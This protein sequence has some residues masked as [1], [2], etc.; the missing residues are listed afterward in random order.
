M[1]QPQKSA[2]KLTTDNRIDRRSYPIPSPN[3]VR[4]S[5]GISRSTGFGVSLAR[6]PKYS[7]CFG[8][9]FSSVVRTPVTVHANP[10]ISFR[11]CRQLLQYNP[12]TSRFSWIA[13]HHLKNPK[14]IRL[15]FT[16]RGPR[17]RAN[18]SFDSVSR[19][20]ASSKIFCKALRFGSE[21][22]SLARAFPKPA[23]KSNLRQTGLNGA[24]FVQACASHSLACKFRSGS[25]AW[26]SLGI[27]SCGT[28][29][30][31]VSGRASRRRGFYYFPP[32][33]MSA[34]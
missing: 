25:P 2:T 20:P 8:Q 10:S 15:L 9:L 12:S 31:T 18:A 32:P 11:K 13:E 14:K 29:C 28:A 3:Q 16:R 7:E 19:T 27:R 24:R 4:G 5:V 22:I 30:R 6:R 33:A 23:C 21:M 34:Q 1:K 17:R 26:L